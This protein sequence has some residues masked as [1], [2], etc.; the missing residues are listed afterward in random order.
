M[1][2]CYLK[3]Q[4]QNYFINTATVSEKKCNLERNILTHQIKGQKLII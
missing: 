3:H 4:L 1:Y 2:L